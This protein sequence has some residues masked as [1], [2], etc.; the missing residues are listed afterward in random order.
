MDGIQYYGFE[1]VNIDTG[2]RRRGLQHP[3]HDEGQQRLRRRRGHERHTCT[4]ATTACSCRRTPTSTSTRGARFQ[5]LTGNLDDFR[6]ALNLDLGLGRHR[7]FISDEASTHADDYAI[8]GSIG[9]ARGK[10][11]TGLVGERRDLGHAGSA[12]AGISYK[13]APGGNLFDGVVYWTGS[14]DDTVFVDGDAQPHRR[15]AKR[16]TTMLNTGLG[17]DNVTVDL[18]GRRRGAHGRLLRPQHL[19][20]LDDRTTRCRSPDRAVGNRRQRHRRRGH[21]RRCRS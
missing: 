12:P 17:N 14:G 11:T 4:A 9:D 18:T 10:S 20:R 19:R 8:T 7:L 13:A 21:A 6:G 15:A 16:T 2:A 5:F 3:G 1:T